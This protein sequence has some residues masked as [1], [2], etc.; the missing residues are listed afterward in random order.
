MTAIFLRG[1]VG[2][3]L[4]LLGSGLR[5]SSGHVFLVCAFNQFVYYSYGEGRIGGLAVRV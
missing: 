2:V 3:K 4:G 1:D 5:V